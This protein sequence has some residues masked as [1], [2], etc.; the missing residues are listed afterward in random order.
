MSHQRGFA[1][2][3]LSTTTPGGSLGRNSEIR[4]VHCRRAPR[5]SPPTRDN[6]GRVVEDSSEGKEVA[7][8]YADQKDEEVARR[9]LLREDGDPFEEPEHDVPPG[10]GIHTCSTHA[11]MIN[12]IVEYWTVGVFVNLWKRSALI[13]MSCI[14]T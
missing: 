3:R 9:R 7:S 13:I 6:Q 10:R 12:P 2:E 4:T 14:L 1:L 5:L 8:K 11:E